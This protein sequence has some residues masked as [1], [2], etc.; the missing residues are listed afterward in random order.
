M[1]KKRFNRLQNEKDD[2]SSSTQ[3]LGTT[4]PEKS[5]EIQ[6]ALDKIDQAVLAIYKDNS[7]K[8]SRAF[9]E[10]IEDARNAGVEVHTHRVPSVLY[11]GQMKFLAYKEE[12]LSTLS[13]QAPQT[14]EPPFPKKGLIS[15]KKGNI[16]T[17]RGSKKTSSSR[18]LEITTHLLEHKYEQSHKVGILEFSI[19]YDCIRATKLLLKNPNVDP[20]TAIDFVTATPTLYHKLQLGYKDIISHISP[21]MLNLLL[22]LRG[23][24]GEYLDPNKIHNITI[25][26]DAPPEF[27]STIL[28]WQGDQGETYI[29]PSNLSV[30][31]RANAY[32]KSNNLLLIL[33]F[34]KSQEEKHPELFKY[35]VSAVSAELNPHRIYFQMAMAHSPELAGRFSDRTVV[36]QQKAEY[37]AHIIKD[38][39]MDCLQDYKNQ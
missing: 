34:A 14:Q 20:K 2:G 35:L 4:P 1:S 28:Q 16:F 32:A 38:H 9:A 27:W 15:A 39:G 7:P 21:E 13:L 36:V 23:K 3:T 5:P 12:L 24:N 29:D 17:G 31:A 25:M 10:A 6:A 11:E 26:H 19:T 37:Y 8:N 30:T 33:A 18:P 22:A